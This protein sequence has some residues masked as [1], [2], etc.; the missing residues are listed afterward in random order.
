LYVHFQEYEKA[1]ADFSM[2]I[3]LKPDDARVYFNRG[4]TYAQL[5]KHEDAICDFT[6]VIRLDPSYTDAYYNRAR[7][8]QALNQFTLS[9][10]DFLKAASLYKQP[11]ERQDCIHHAT[12]NAMNA[13]LKQQEAWNAQQQSRESKSS[14]S[15]TISDT[16]TVSN[17]GTMSN[18]EPTNQSFSDCT[19]CMTAKADHVV[20]G[21]MH[22]C[23][24][25]DCAQLYDP[26]FVMRCDP[27]LR[28][29]CPAP[30]KTCPR[31]RG[32]IES[33]RKL[34]V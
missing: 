14:G 20:L 32:S 28:S 22:V 12:E 13:Q 26:F 25:R 24:C 8:Y 16:D 33:I 7:Q 6:T 27:E 31:C 18:V 1:F 9:A 5:N 11:H 2:I 4:N 10:R 15:S 23:F 21:C 19:I 30:Q 3:R 34:F 17:I 29:L